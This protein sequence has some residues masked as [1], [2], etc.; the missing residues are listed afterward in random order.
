MDPWLEHPAHWPDVHH[1]LISAIQ[2]SLSDQVR[3]RYVARV[4]ERVYISDERDPG[5]RC[6]IPDVHISDSRA[7]AAS[8]P[9]FVSDEG[10]VAVAEPLVR[11]TLLDRE[12]H[13]AYLTLVDVDKR[14]VVTVLEVLSPTNKYPHAEGQKS[15]LRKRHEVLQSATNLVEIDLL[16]GGERILVEPGLPECEYVAHVSRPG[17][18]PEGLIWPIRLNQ[19]LPI[20]PVPLRPDDDDVRL[21]LQSAL[22]SFY[23]RA[24][25]DLILDYAAEPVPTLEATW[26][27]WA[28]ELL[29]AR[30]VRG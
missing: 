22:A 4:E 15:Y 27:R 6:I 12:V 26:S 7:G 16:R 24:G 9:I 17:H 1:H 11:V 25:Y 19:R 2:A 5:R 30:G 10:G 8:P 21:D 23:D 13:E 14:E 29:H 28:D 18:R 20:L 3:P